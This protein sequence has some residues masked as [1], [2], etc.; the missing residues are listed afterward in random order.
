MVRGCYTNTRPVVGNWTPHIARYGLR[1]PGVRRQGW[2]SAVCS[3]S[4]SIPAC[5]GRDTQ[6]SGG[7]LMH[8]V[9]RGAPHVH[10]LPSFGWQSLAAKPFTVGVG[11]P[12][13]S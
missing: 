4:G 8:D 7:V 3:T 9:Y 2:R 13:G 12:V 5:V 10:H 1:M 6:P 11:G